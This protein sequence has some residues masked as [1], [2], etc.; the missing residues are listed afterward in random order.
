MEVVE[1]H[2]RRQRAID[3]ARRARRRHPRQ[4]DHVPRR[5]AQPR[6]EL[7]Q[8]RR[9]QLPPPKRALRQETEAQLQVMRVGTQRVRRRLA[10]KAVTHKRLGRRDRDAHRVHDRPAHPAR[11]RHHPL[12]AEPAPVHPLK[13][14]RMPDDPR[15][16]CA[17]RRPEPDSRRSAEAEAS[18]ASAETAAVRPF[19]SSG[20]GLARA[21]HH[22]ENSH[23][24]TTR[25][26]LEPILGAEDLVGRG[27]HHCQSL[28]NSMLACSAKPLRVVTDHMGA[29]HTSSSRWYLVAKTV[30]HRV[31]LP[32][33]PARG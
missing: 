7:P 26:G 5:P 28:V 20:T 30:P 13:V 31:L 12:R 8:L 11:R 4:Q 27:R 9:R 25:R 10:L 17:R 32:R 18:R 22:A 24:P 33:S 16:P 6:H 15:P 3:R 29:R 23:Q 14:R 19:R 2:H 21:S 1:R